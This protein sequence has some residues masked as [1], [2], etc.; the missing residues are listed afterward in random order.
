MPHHAPIHLGLHCL[1][2]YTFQRERERER[3]RK[4]KRDRQQT[5][6]QTDL[7]KSE[8]EREKEKWKFGNFRENF[9]FANSIKRY[10]SD[11]KN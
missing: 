4:R 10:I 5:D 6:K 1:P 9:I 2:N 11:V 3:E 8:T 7:E